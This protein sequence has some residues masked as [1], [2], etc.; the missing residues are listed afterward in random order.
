MKMNKI[1]IDINE[2]SEKIGVSVGTLYQWVSQKKIP[3]VKCGRLTKFSLE[4]INNWI[5]AHS[6]RTKDHNK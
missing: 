3:Y 4:D 1:L 6:V 5:R 2:L